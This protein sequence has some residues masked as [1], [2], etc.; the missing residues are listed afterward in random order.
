MRCMNLIRENQVDEMKKL[1][2]HA[3]HLSQARVALTR[4][5]TAFLFAAEDPVND[6]NLERGVEGGSCCS[7]EVIMKNSSFLS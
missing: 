6:D 3:L 7:G 4:S 5:L 2:T 1:P